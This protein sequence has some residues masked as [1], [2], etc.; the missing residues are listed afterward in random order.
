MNENVQELMRAWLEAERAH[1]EYLARFVAVAT[2]EPD[3]P[4]PVPDATFTEAEIKE[5]ARLRAIAVKAYDSWLESL[6]GSA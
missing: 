6:L 5:T 3:K 4:I 2:W 1:E